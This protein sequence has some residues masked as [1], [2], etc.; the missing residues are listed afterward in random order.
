MFYYCVVRQHIHAIECGMFYYCV[1]SNIFMLQ[2]VALRFLTYMIQAKVVMVMCMFGYLTFV[3]FG[4]FR[5]FGSSNPLENFVCI[6]KV[7]FKRSLFNSQK[8][9]LSFKN[10][11]KLVQCIWRSKCFK[12]CK[13]RQPD[14]PY[15]LVKC[16]RIRDDNLV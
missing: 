5:V 13:R 9:C 2:D 11:P 4:A 10:A 8:Q 7:Y 14:K 3:V 1:V 15:F 16:I 12:S 6:V